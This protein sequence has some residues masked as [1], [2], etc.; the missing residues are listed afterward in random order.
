MSQDSCITRHF[1]HYRTLSKNDETLLASLEQSPSKVR[2]DQIL[3]QEGDSAREFC[4]L[5]RGW[6][7]SFRHME[8]GSRQIL[9]IYLPGDIIGLREFAFKE[10]LAGVAMLEDG[11]VCHFPHRRLLNVFRESLTLSAIFF[12]ISSHQQALLTE[13]L[14]NLARRSAR[15]RLAHLIYEMYVRLERT[16][17][18]DGNSIRLP[19]SQQHLGDALGLSSVHVSRTLTTFR[20]EGLIL[21][22]RQRIELPD[23]AALAR[24]AEFADAY[25][26]DGIAHFFTTERDS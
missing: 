24:E 5:S 3:W 11:V 16:R 20:E 18:R 6:A 15:Q 13:R 4:T 8:D 2:A 22:A 7:Y 21:R 12:A 17:A 26:N 25:L 10:R 14:V 19:L 9:E 1:E 23:P